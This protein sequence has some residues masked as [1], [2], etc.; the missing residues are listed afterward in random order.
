M[1]ISHKVLSMIGLL[2]LSSM[3]LGSRSSTE[4]LPQVN[5]E[6][7][8]KAAYLYN[9]LSLFEWPAQASQDTLTIAILGD[10]PFGDIFDP[11]QGRAI[12]GKPLAVVHFPEID[13]SETAKRIGDCHILF[14][15]K[16]E[17][18]RV[19][20]ILTTLSNYSLLTVGEV[21]DFTK[22]GGGIKF[23]FE[24]NSIRFELNLRVI[25]QNRLQVA[26]QLL[27]LAKIYEGP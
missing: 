20:E 12:K 10:N 26:P 24:D 25:D 3:W 8:I 7:Q 9:F 5:R 19:P 1:P 17:E 15:S 27:R 18:K 22:E 13:T 14:V 6:Y 21:E 2:L 23:Y 16:S 4:R 11:L